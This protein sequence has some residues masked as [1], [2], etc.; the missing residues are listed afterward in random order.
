MQ[1]KHNY[2]KLGG[3]YESMVSRDSGSV[4]AAADE[5]VK[6]FRRQSQD[7]QTT[8]KP[9]QTELVYGLL[10]DLAAENPGKNP[11][12]YLTV[13]KTYSTFVKRAKDIIR[14]IDG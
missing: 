2:K 6:N 10:R 1:D 8:S 7:D 12:G 9:T 3:I 14:R 13:F 4:A 11:A 5:W